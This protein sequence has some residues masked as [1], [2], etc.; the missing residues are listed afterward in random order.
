M[1]TPAYHI[2]ITVPGQP[3]GKAR[4][5]VVR[6]HTY[7]PVETTKAEWDIGW[8]A[9]QAGAQ[10]TAAPVALTV[11]AYFRV[12]PRWPKRWREDALT[13][14]LHHTRKPDGDNVLKLVGDALN[15]IIWE[16]DGQVVRATVEKW[17]SDLPRLEIEIEVLR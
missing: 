7:T 5:R 17:Y 6:G 11:R 13:G 3:T 1:V 2:V 10:I 16:D 4:P 14:V 15:H 12:P 9:K 8:L